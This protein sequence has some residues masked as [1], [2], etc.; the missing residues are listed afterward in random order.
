AAATPAKQ[1]VNRPRLLPS[2]AM[3]ATAT[4][5]EKVQSRPRPPAR[6]T[7]R[8]ARYWTP[9]IRKATQHLRRKPHASRRNGASLLNRRC[10]RPKAA[11]GSRPGWRERSARAAL[12]LRTGGRSCAI[13]LSPRRR[14]IIAGF[15]PTGA[16]LPEDFI[17]LRSNAM[18]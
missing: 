18:V 4:A 7:A 15:L 2:P 6:D 1:D 14:P 8:S 12:R 3:A 16:L 9:E 11:D 10:A 5:G 17:C 13:S